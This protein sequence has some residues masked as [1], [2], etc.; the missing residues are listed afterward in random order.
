[1][2]PH[3]LRVTF[4]R[5]GAALLALAA[6][7][8][9]MAAVQAPQPPLRFTVM[10]DGRPLAVWARRPATPTGVIVLVHGRTWSSRPDFDLQVPG[11]PRSVLASFAARGLAAYAVD[12]RGYGGTP[13][14]VPAR[15]TPT[16]AAADLE[17]VLAWVAREH[18]ALPPPALV[19]WSRGAA[20]AMLAA[21]QAPAR[22]SALVVF[23]FAFDPQARFADVE[24]PP[25]PGERNTAAAAAS[26]FISPAVTPRAVIRAFVAQA[27]Q[28]DPV[29]ADVRGDAEFNALQPAR[30]TMPTLVLYGSRDPG[31]SPADA[32]AML[33][34]VGTPAK[35]RVVLEGADHAAHLEDTHDAW[36]DAICTFLRRHPASIAPGRRR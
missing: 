25:T 17:A 3:N 10:S 8:T 1:M 29:L 14:D 6:G 32:K 9:A 35:Q 26:D 21:Q 13:A 20:I 12:L 24:P 18:P 30:L 34:A 4:L 22:L 27:L 19:G 28:A 16:R 15:M 33:A 5:A 11:L 7:A 31:V 23:G 36:T 2:L